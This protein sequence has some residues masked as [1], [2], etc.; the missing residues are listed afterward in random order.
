M[1][2]MKLSYIL[3]FLNLD[4]LIL[5]IPDL[6]LFRLSKKM[7]HFNLKLVQHGLLNN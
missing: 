2:R 4:V 1:N 6:L 5:M 3:D 7:C